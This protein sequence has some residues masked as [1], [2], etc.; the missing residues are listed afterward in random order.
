MRIFIDTNVVVDFCSE[1]EPFFQEAS[2]IFDMGT[3]GEVEI[4]I[5]S[6]SFVNMAYVLRKTFA[7]DDLH[8]RLKKMSDRCI[9]SSVD[10]DT[11]RTAISLNS[12]DFEDCVQCESAKLAKADL[13]VTRDEKGFTDLGVLFVS[14][15]EFIT[16]CQ[17]ADEATEEAQ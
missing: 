15:T 2:D 16:M 13:I 6:L 7:K 8:E 4:V 3:R 10:G 11:I 12:K 17:Q 1:R 5:S 14:P 9:I